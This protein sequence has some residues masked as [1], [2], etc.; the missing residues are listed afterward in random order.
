MVLL[1]FWN[2]RDSKKVCLIAC[3]SN[4]LISYN[5]SCKIFSFYTLQN[6]HLL[7]WLLHGPVLCDHVMKDSFIK[8]IH[9]DRIKASHGICN[10]KFPVFCGSNVIML[11]LHSFSKFLRWIYLFFVKGWGRE[12]LP[13]CIQRRVSLFV[14]A[15]LFVLPQN[16][17]EFIQDTK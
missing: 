7:N 12:A 14:A 16:L 2:A 15:Q 3:L 11:H 6:K 10:S 5:F 9:K 17:L 13:V 8:H 1:A 4:I